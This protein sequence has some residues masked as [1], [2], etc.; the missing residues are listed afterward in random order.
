MEFFPENL[1]CLMPIIFS[2]RALTSHKSDCQPFR[3][4]GARFTR[5]ISGAIIEIR[6]YVFELAAKILPKQFLRKG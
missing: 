6:A 2:H 4:V 1:S 3:G 5:F